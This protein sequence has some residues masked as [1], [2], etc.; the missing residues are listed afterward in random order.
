MVIRFPEKLQRL[1]ECAPFPLYAVG[2]AVRDALA[3][4]PASP[5]IDLAAPA[6]AEEFSRLAQRCGLQVHGVYKNTGTVNFG[7][8]AQKFEFTSFRT[9]TYRRGEHAPAAVAFT[10]DIRTDALRRDFLC[11]AVYYDIAKGT[12][13]DP[14]GGADDAR[15]HVLRTTR[16]AEEVFAEDGLRLMRLA[17]QA[18]QLGFA[19]AEECVE[20]ARQNAARICFISPERI[21]AEL[22][23]ILHADEKYGRRYAHYEGLKL[24]E[25]TEVLGHI[26]PELA[27][28]KG[29][30]QRADFHDHDVLEHSFRACKYAD[31]RV[32]LSALLHDVGKPAVY[33]QTGRYHG[34]DAAGEPIAR[35]VLARLK[36]PKKLTETVCRLVL[37][38]MYDLD[39]RTRESK[40]RT[41]LVRNH[42]VYELL[43]LVKQADYSGCK[44]DLS[45]CPTIRKW[46]EIRARMAAEGVP[47]TLRGL[48]VRGDELRGVV[49]VQKTGDVLQKLLLFC[50]LDGR[51]NRRETLLEEAARIAADGAKT[52]KNK[53]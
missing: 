39:G 47:F 44:D 14:L 16:A 43:L 45:P 9:D 30:P 36:A 28:G 48:A 20:G 26:L 33:R 42:D 8:G 4:L 17:R 40:V 52:G 1:A 21:F 31:A 49:E 11:N 2:G 51:R 46:E 35:A 25:R 3:G 27:A 23:A 24:L 19:P 53:A 15:A 34:H 10:Q 37:L 6:S 32:R 41:F 18:A 13:E 22:Q 29:L 12:L 5:D 38:H 50:A 7:D